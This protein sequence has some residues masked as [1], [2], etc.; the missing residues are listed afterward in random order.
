MDRPLQASGCVQGSATWTVS[1]SGTAGSSN[2]NGSSGTCTANVQRVRQLSVGFW[3]DIYKG[4][5]GRARVGLEYE[6]VTL[7]LFS[8]TAGAGLAANTANTG[9]HP[10]NNIS[11]A[12]I[13]STERG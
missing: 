6:Y 5:L 9:Q 3:Q 8:G 12:T 11:S 4:D 1:T 7:D 2:F 10:N 13:R